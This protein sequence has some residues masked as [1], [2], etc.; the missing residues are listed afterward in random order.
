[1]HQQTDDDNS[2]TAPKPFKVLQC[3]ILVTLF[4]IGACTVW[5]LWRQDMLTLGKAI[6]TVHEYPVLSP[7][8]FVAVYAVAMFFIIPTLPLNI[9]A[10]LIWGG[11]LGAVYTVLGSTLGG[12][13]AFIFSRSAFGQPLARSFQ[14]RLMKGLVQTVSKGG[15]RVVAFVRLNPV[16]PSG[17]VNFLFGLTSLSFRT[18]LWATLVFSFPMAWVIAYLGFS[19]GS[20]MLNG[21]IAV[22]L[23]TLG[24]LC[25]LALLIYL[26]KRAMPS[27]KNKAAG[28]TRP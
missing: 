11:L 8:L 4:I 6:A 10:G 22:L 5:N 20:L 15:W 17:V 3:V 13:F 24:I 26:G 1:M 2:K 12:C 25:G 7:V 19:T 27:G 21:D 23:R 9:G 28:P 14:F 18:F 16:I